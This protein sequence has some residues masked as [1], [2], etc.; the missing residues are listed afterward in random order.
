MLKSGDIPVTAVAKKFGVVRA[1][2]YRN[3]H[4]SRAGGP[5]R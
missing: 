4:A 2:L 1:R 3:M 5:V